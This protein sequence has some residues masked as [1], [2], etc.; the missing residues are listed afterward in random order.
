SVIAGMERFERFIR[1]ERPDLEPGYFTVIRAGWL[2]MGVGSAST[3][4]VLIRL[5]GPSTDPEDDELLEAKEVTNLEGIPCLAA[6]TNPLAVRV[7]DGT[8]QLG[9]LKHD[10]LAVGPTMLIPS[11]ADRAEHWLE[12]WV[13]S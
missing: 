5:Q 13:S 1:R 4:K 9:R 12:W 7:I 11:A 10:I 3:R 2:H 8:R 6:P